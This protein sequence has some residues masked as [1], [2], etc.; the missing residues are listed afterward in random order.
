MEKILLEGLEKHKA[1]FD[2]YMSRAKLKYNYNRIVDVYRPLSFMM[3]G[4]YLYQF[5][6]DQGV[7]LDNF[8]QKFKEFSENMPKFLVN[9][10]LNNTIQNESLDFINAD[11]DQKV[12][13]LVEEAVILHKNET[14]EDLNESDK[15][16]LRELFKAQ[17]G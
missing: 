8:D 12:E 1:E 3:G 16:L 13:I 7:T 17:L 9:S 15:N 11:K 4:F 5:F 6:N 14:G 10:L 2:K